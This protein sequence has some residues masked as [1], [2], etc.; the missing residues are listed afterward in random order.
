M[1]SKDR[2]VECPHCPKK[3]FVSKRKLKIHMKNVHDQ[4]A[5]SAQC[6]DCGAL[7]QNHVKLRGHR[8]RFHVKDSVSCPS[9]E[10]NFGT[11]AALKKHYA[12]LHVEKLYKCVFCQKSFT[13]YSNFKVHLKREHEIFEAA[14]EDTV[15]VVETEPETDLLEGKVK[16]AVDALS[17]RI[18]RI[19]GQTLLNCEKCN[20][21]FENE[22]SFNLHEKTSHSDRFS[23][24][25][26]RR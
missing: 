7:F 15:T 2:T 11:P 1:A 20:K 17:P 4:S 8:K 21:V 3:K 18:V 22:K 13:Q 25:I 14:E 19:I 5:I 16:D 24:S 23:C 6:D 9:C 12:T 26:C 10:L